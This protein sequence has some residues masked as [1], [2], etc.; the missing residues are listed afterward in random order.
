MVILL[1]GSLSRRGLSGFVGY[2]P[3]DVKHMFMHMCECD[4]TP[5]GKHAVIPNLV[6]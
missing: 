4:V 5:L 3:S 1:L 6:M 2:G